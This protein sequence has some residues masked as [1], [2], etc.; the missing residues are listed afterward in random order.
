MCSKKNFHTGGD[1][2]G[3]IMR[4]LHIYKDYLPVC[5]GIENYIR[6]LSEAH[7]GAGHDLSVVCCDPE[8]GESSDT[9]NGVRVL[10]VPRW[11]TF[12]SMPIAPALFGAVK[13]LNPDIIHLHSPFPLG[14][15]AALVSGGR[16]PVVVTHH[17]DVVR[18]RLLMVAYAPFYR[19]F[20]NRVDRII[21]TSAAYAESSPWLQR[22]S[23]KCCVIPLGI[24]LQRFTPDPDSHNPPFKLL[25]VGRLRYYKGLDLLLRAMPELPG[26]MLDVAGRGPMEG[27]WKR[28][29]SQLGLDERVNFLGD[30]SDDDLPGIYRSADLFVLPANCRAEAFGTVLL[31]AMA[32]GLPCITTDVGSGTSWVVQNG[33]TGFVIPAGDIRSLVSSVRNVLQN[34]NLRNSMAESARRRARD[35]FS[36][37]LL[38][39]RVMT[40]YRSLFPPRQ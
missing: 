25:F 37:K 6:V 36:E 28:L 3:R 38:C 33:D 11:F 24:D 2:T 29:S 35:H 21:A 17:S 32:S 12:R 7:A 19:R 4:I 9:I 15:Q 39:D 14:E 8:R 26:V 16:C 30:V 31:E 1:D 10:R 13:R 23:D 20:L 18:Q 5:G 27:E 40:L 22:Y 34:K